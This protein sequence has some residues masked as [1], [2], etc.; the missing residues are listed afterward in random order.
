LLTHFR[1]R[2]R[3]PTVRTIRRWRLVVLGIVVLLMSAAPSAASAQTQRTALSG[4]EKLY[5]GPPTRTWS[6]GGWTVVHGLPLTGTFAFGGAGV[7][8]VGTVTR[9]DNA[10]YDAAGNGTVV[11]IISFTDARTGVTCRGPS[12]GKLIGFAL[13][14]SVVAPC[15]DGRLLRGDVRDTGLLVD[16]QGTVIGVTGEFNGVLL[17]PGG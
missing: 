8:L 10:K 7:S 14:G 5:F 12:P 9:V 1:R 17:T 13:V 6:A 2:R 16:A 4:E 15:S 11:G 3:R